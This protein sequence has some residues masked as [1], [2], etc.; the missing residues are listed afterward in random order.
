MFDQKY[1]NQS[2]NRK[3][4]EH[5]SALPVDIVQQDYEKEKILHNHT[6][7]VPGLCEDVDKYTVI[8]HSST[9]D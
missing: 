9:P 3:T 5:L 4:L 6:E 7:G 8:S 2:K 1:F